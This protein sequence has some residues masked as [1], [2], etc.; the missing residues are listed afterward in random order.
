M[1]SGKILLGV[2][3]GVAA[4]ALIG[5]LFAPDKGSKTRRRIIE[6]GVD[7]SDELSDRFEEFCESIND[8]LDSKDELIDKGKAKYDTAKK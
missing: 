7:Y 2:L 6:K 4:S 3:A 8:K 5:I 1:N